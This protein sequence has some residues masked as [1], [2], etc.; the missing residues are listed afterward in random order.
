MDFDS[1]IRSSYSWVSATNIIWFIAFFWIA[2]PFITILP[3]VFSTGLIYSQATMPLAVLLYDILYVVLILGVILLIQHSLIQKHARVSS[4]S[5]RKIIDLIFLVFVELGYVFFWTISVKL[6]KIQHLTL[7]FSALFGYL[8]LISFNA[9]ILVLF[10]W[11][12]LGY[13][14]IAIRNMVMVFFSTTIFC[15]KESLSI[16]GAIK[17]SWAITHNRVVDTF[18]SIL[19]SVFLAFVLFSFVTLVLG[20]FSSIVLRFFFIDSLA[21]SLGIKVSMAFGLGVALIAYHFMIA[22]VFTQLEGHKVAS[23]RIKRILSRR[24]LSSKNQKLASPRRSFAKKKVV[25]K[26]SKR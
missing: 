1:I 21:F 16:K 23:S 5:A 19:V 20:A 7:I 24:V 25:K 13:V 6:R 3:Q 9:V 12:L 18:S 8:F 4:L 26:K 15:N 2:L 22:E 14:S 17:E 11:S 10:S